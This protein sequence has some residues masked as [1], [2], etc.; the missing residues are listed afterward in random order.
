MGTEMKKIDM[1]KSHI[2]AYTRNDGVVVG[3]HDDSRQSK[4]KYDHPSVVGHAEKLE[5]GS[6]GVAHGFHFAGRRYSNT[7]KTGTS[8]HDG[9]P[10]RHFREVTEKEGAG[11]DVWLDHGGR[12]HADALTDVSRLRQEYEAH[13]KASQ[14]GKPKIAA[15]SVDVQ[16]ADRYEYANGKK[17][18]GKGSW[19]FSPHKSHDFGK[20]GDKAG[21]HFF[22]SNYDTTYGDAKKQAKAWAAEKGHR[23]IHIQS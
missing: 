6:A 12:V 21:E 8:N 19:I 11:Q 22:Q 16:G 4:S 23:T 1:L 15:S 20:H 3:A 17:P 13:Q 9:T 18:G 5:G 7:G 14:S 2:A 10:V